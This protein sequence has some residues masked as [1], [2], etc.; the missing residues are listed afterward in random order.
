MKIGSIGLG[1][2]GRP[3]AMHL[4]NAGYQL[5]LYARRPETLLPFEGA[6]ATV[7]MN[8]AAEYSRSMVRE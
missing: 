6:G 4:H 3:C 7:C 1:L 5:A 8:P 2:M